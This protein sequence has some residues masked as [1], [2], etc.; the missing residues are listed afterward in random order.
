[1][2]QTQDAFSQE[3]T[4]QRGKILAL[5][6]LVC[7]GRHTLTGMLTTAG[8]QFNDWSADYRLF[9]KDRFEPDKLFAHVRKNLLLEIPESEP[10]VCCMDDSLFRKTGKKTYGVGYWRDPL[11]PP[12]HVNLILG[13]RILQIS[14]AWVSGHKP[15]PARMIPIDFLHCPKVK[16][17]PKNAS[18]KDQ[19]AYRQLQ[20]KLKISAIGAQRL[21][22]LREALDEEPDGMNRQLIVSVDGSYTNGTVLKNMP[23]RTTLIGRIRKDA[24]LFFL[25]EQAAEGTRGRK[26]VY[27][28]RVPTPEELRQ[29]DDL[30][31]QRIEA[32]AAGKTHSFK[33]KTFAPLRWRTAGQKHNLRLIIIAPLGYRLSQASRIF[34]RR[35]AYLIC[36]DPDLP[37]RKVLQMYLWRWGI[38]VNFRDEKCL[39]GAGQAQVRNEKSVQNLPAL[40]IAAYAM[41][42]IAAEK[43]FGQSKQ[44][45]LILPLPKWRNKKKAK[46][47]STQQM[48]TQLRVDLWCKSLDEKNFYGFKHKP[49]YIQ[50]TKKWKPDITS[51]VLFASN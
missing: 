24:R 18:P 5:S 3:R 12:F 38:E 20:K 43:T 25:P 10:F 29:S 13:Q 21:Q 49:S 26:R 8:R 48:I 16:K 11:G 35:P 30:P 27:G 41:L 42:L 50:N 2:D 1:M 9:S 36:T 7:L 31:F 51:A 22:K 23:S 45:S 6:A 47:L 44:T 17:P 40:I 34:Y 33:I 46:R 19:A 39:L 14:A 28:E 32:W 15:G 37:V 4:W